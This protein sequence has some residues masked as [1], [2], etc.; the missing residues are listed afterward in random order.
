MGITDDSVKLLAFIYDKYTEDSD[1]ISTDDVKNEF[2]W[3]SSRINRAIDYLDDMN[4]I[5][6]VKSLG[7][8]DGVYNFTITRLT[9]KGVKTIENEKEFKNKFGVEIGVPGII[10]AK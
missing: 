10:K 5:K 3:D 6:I 1:Q 4:L 2:N 8:S 9:P 7:N